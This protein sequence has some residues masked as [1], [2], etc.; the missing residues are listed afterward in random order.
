[1]KEAYRLQKND[2]SIQL[3]KSELKLA[4]FF[5]Y[6]DKKLPAFAIVKE[7]FW[8]IL[9]KLTSIIHEMDSPGS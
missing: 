7:K 9:Q 1:M 4:V 2:L 3:T 6:T 8:I 5:I